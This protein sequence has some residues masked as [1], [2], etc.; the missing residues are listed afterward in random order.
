[1]LSKYTL[2]TKLL[3]WQSLIRSIYIKSL[4]ICLGLAINTS[5]QKVQSVLKIKTLQ[6]RLRKIQVQNSYKTEDKK[7]RK[8]INEL[9]V[10]N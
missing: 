9:D 3:I 8:I 1:M 2:K 5:N 7:D 10:Q 6:E 4:K